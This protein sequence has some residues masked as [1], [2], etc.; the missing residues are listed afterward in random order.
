MK[1]S[2]I[3]AR[4]VGRNMRR[5]VLSG[6]AIAISALVIV[7]LFSLIEGMKVDLRY[8]IATFVSGDIRIRS[9]DYE[10]SA[11][12]NA[13]IYAM[14]NADEILATVR[15]HPR[16]AMVS[17]RVNFGVSIYRD[18]SNHFAAGAGVD[19]DREVAFQDLDDS[20]IEG[21]PAEMGT[22]EAVVAVGL[23]RDLGIGIGDKITMLS[24]TRQR[25]SNA[26]T[27]E[28]VG[29]ARFPIAALNKS[30]FLAPLDRVQYFLRMP[31]A[32][33]EVLVKTAPDTDTLVVADEINA[34]LS[35]AGLA[36]VEATSWRRISTSYTFIELADT[37][38]GFFALFFFLL[39]STIIVN[40]TMMVVYERTRE[41]GTLAAM[42][43]TGREIVTLF[44]LEALFIAVVGAAVGTALGA[45]MN[46]V[47]GAVGYD[48]SSAMGDMEFELSG[49]IYPLVNLR[50]TIF[51]FVYAVLVSAA[52][53]L[54]P[55]RRAVKIQPVEAL[56][57]V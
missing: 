16:V 5:S 43:M 14:D 6:L 4:N 20:L 51:V 29:I 50:S 45:G 40:T 48:L 34:E 2:T 22:D 33:T 23:S 42:G 26:F 21:R 39:A 57:A 53:S 56:R 32:I 52:A 30:Y 54:F 7:T 35:D 12:V 44:F 9:A 13:L 27:L 47:A 37:I 11:G 41:I 38:Y 46:L 28:I 49:V 8:N 24:Q 10:E 55:S 17:P 25:S 3:A 31:N 1:L 19:F 15:D 36:G 18:G